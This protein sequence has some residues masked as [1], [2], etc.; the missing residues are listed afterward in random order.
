MLGHNSSHLILTRKHG[1]GVASVIKATYKNRPI[2]T[3][4]PLTRWS[5]LISLGMT[6]TDI[7]Y[8]LKW[9]PATGTMSDVRWH[10]C[11]KLITSISSWEIRQVSVEGHATKYLI[12][13]LHQ[14]RTEEER[15][16]CHRF[17]R[18]EGDVTTKCCVG[19]SIASQNR[20]MTLE[21]KQ[22]KPK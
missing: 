15:L 21:E 13:T 7:V 6:P 2:S 11:P 17:G 18:H 19:S 1:T 5:G 16:N 10:S 22:M 8:P 9:Y 4:A 12:S 3:D 14:S 20:K